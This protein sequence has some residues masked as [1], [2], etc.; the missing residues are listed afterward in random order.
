MARAVWQP[1]AYRLTCAHRNCVG[2]ASRHT[3]R[4]DLPVE[5]SRFGLGTGLVGPGVSRS[6]HEE[7]ARIVKRYRTM[8][9]ASNTATRAAE[10]SATRTPGFRFAFRPH[11]G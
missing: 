5:E 4:A 3:V 9:D 10:F 6:P 11:G 7:G 2:A 8:G 1:V